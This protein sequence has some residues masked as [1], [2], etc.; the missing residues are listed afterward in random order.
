V[1]EAEWGAWSAPTRV[2]IEHSPVWAFA[3][4]VKD[5]NPVYASEGAARASGLDG[6]PCP[7]T[8]TFGMSAWGTF[9][10]MQPA[11]AP[12][13]T[14][15]AAVTAALAEA[16]GMHLHGEQLFE[17][18]R[19]PLVGDV[20]EGRRRISKPIRKEGRRPLDMTYHQTEWRDAAGELVVR[21]QTT[22]LFIPDA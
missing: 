10:D 9:P 5:K 16:K 22:A 18:A 13:P 21:E 4:A 20:L 17:Y 19:T 12:P 15:T 1:T 11:G 7:P 14:D 8:Y 6:V 3:R 2:R